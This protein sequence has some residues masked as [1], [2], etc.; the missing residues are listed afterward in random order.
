MR[1]P[2]SVILHLFIYLKQCL[3]LNLDFF[4]FFARLSTSESL[5]CF[6]LYAFSTKAKDVYCCALFFT[7]DSG[8]LNSHSHA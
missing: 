4:F 5:Q 6:C 2:S 3:S 7:L 8:D 1:M